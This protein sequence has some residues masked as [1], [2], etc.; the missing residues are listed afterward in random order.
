VI[1][2]LLYAIGGRDSASVLATNERYG[3]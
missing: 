1:S 3:P 2:N